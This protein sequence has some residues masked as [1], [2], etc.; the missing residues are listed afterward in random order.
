MSESDPLALADYVPGTAVA[1]DDSARWPGLDSAGR[2]RL[3]GIL[4]HRHAPRWRH[5]TGHRLD[6]AGIASAR[7]FPT[8]DGWLE[9]HLAVARRLPAY[10]GRGPLPRLR[11]FPLIGRDDLMADISAFVPLDADLDRMVTGSSSGTTGHALLIPDDIEDVARTFW[12]LVRLVTDHADRWTPEPGRLALAHIVHQRQ[13]FTYASALPG[14]DGAVMARLNL[15]PR[16]W[17]PADRDAFLADTNPQVFSGCPTSLA[18]LLT[19]PAAQRPA[20]WR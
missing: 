1:L 11:D 18:A 10:R 16:E 17:A 5:R 15:D 20:R 8:L 3:D 4:D 13:A 14:F 12:L 9:Q 2:A 19:S 6:P 7:T